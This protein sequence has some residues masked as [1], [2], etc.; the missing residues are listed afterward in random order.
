[1]TRTAG[2]DTKELNYGAVLGAMQ[3][4]LA[5]NLAMNSKGWAAAL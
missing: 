5:G 2:R 4:S 3:I 1:M